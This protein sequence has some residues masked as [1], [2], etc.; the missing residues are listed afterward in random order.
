M[1]PS[2]LASKPSLT[3]TLI[4]LWCKLMLKTFLIMFFELLFLNSCVIS[5]GL[6]WSLSPL[7]GCFIVFILL[8]ITSMG[9]IWKG[10]HYQIIFWHEVRWPHRRSI[11]CF[12][13]LSSSFKDHHACPQLRLSILNKGYSH[14]GAYEWNYV[15]L[16]HLSTQLALIG[17]RVKVSKCKLWNP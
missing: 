8:F 12:V 6:W 14:H 10:H 4:G 17:L 7:L 13:P 15:C 3:Y 2:F 11:I 1:R 16:D 5:R 9:G